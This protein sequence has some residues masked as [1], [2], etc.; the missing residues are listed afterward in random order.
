MGRGRNGNRG[1]RNERGRH[2]TNSGNRTTSTFKGH[3]TEMNG[4]VFECFNEGTK[5]GQSSK[6]LEALGEYIANNLKNLGDMMSLTEELITPE[7]TLPVTQST[8]AAADP[9]L[10]ALWKEEVIDYSKQRL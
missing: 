6:T 5:Q 4:H 1:R 3:T 9:L 10:A 7:V 2:N 8:I